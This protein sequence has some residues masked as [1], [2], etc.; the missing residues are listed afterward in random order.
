MLL[1]WPIWWKVGGSEGCCVDQSA[2]GDDD[3]HDDGDD[4]GH[5]QVQE[6][7][8]PLEATTLQR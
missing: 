3:D 2:H 8:E 7:H 1:R 6:Q 5:S 4:G